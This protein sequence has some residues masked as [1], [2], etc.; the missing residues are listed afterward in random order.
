MGFIKS[1]MHDITQE[2]IC[3]IAQHLY[4]YSLI[5]VSVYVC[6]C[7]RGNSLKEV[8]V[9]FS[10]AIDWCWG[11]PFFTLFTEARHQVYCMLIR[12]SEDNR[13]RRICHNSRFNFHINRWCT[14]LSSHMHK[15][16]LAFPAFAYN[17]P[18]ILLKPTNRWPLKK[19]YST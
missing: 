10:A 1:D 19:K 17:F 2:D 14:L 6:A 13:R 9:G 18:H 12:G 11:N 15:T 3:L 4:Q 5:T 8:S 16:T 7:E